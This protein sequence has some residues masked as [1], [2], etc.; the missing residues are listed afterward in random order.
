MRML[1]VAVLAALLGGG[2][3]AGGAAQT[4]APQHG[5]RD[6]AQKTVTIAGTVLAINGDLVQF[7]EDDGTTITVD[8]HQL[9]AAGQPLTLGGHFALHGYFVNDMFV[10]RANAART[11]A[12]SN[13]YPAAGGTASVQG[14]ITSIEGS[15]VTIMQGLFS[16]IAIDDQLAV[17]RGM[18]QHLSVG[19]SV[20]AYGYWSGGTFF[21]T[22]IG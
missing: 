12:I 2:P 15:S 11:G 17:N 14:I 16:T 9:I 19:R 8:Q 22:S 21:A 1:G 6:R 5:S 10:A 4:P 7:R 20:T 13:G 3:L 18:A